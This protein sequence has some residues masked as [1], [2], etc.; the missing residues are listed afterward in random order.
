MGGALLF[1]ENA[2]LAIITQFL[3]ISRSFLVVAVCPT[4]ISELCIRLSFSDHFTISV[5]DFHSFYGFS[6][7][8]FCTQFLDSASGHYTVT[9]ALYILALFNVNFPCVILMIIIFS[10]KLLH[11]RG[12][13]E[14]SKF[15]LTNLP[16]ICCCNM[17]ILKFCLLVIISG[18]WLAIGWSWFEVCDSE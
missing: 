10:F 12:L 8:I 2:F 15:N 4:L 1:Q 7:S 17:K 18:E 14:R 6:N 13:I 16:T 3:S 11:F 9:P 5:F